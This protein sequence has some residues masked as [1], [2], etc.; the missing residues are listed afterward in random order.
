MAGINAVS[1]SGNSSEAQAMLVK[2]QQKLATDLAAKA[3]EKV[4]DADRQAVAR[5]QQAAQQSPS[6]SGGSTLD[7]TA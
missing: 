6:A 2:Y 7:V 4:I 5:A 1:S 3:A